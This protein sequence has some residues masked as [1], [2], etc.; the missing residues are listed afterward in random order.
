MRTSIVTIVLM[1][2]F[3]ALIHAQ[4]NQ[5]RAKELKEQAE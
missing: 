1:L 2:C 3:N 5:D 4:T